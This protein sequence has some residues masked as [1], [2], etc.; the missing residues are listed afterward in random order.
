[1]VVRALRVGIAPVQ[2]RVLRQVRFLPRTLYGCGA[3]Q[4]DIIKVVASSATHRRDG[5]VPFGWV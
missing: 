4:P 3:R 2:F 5:H 1:M